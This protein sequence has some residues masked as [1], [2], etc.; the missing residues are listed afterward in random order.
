LRHMHNWRHVTGL[1]WGGDVN[2]HVAGQEE[3]TLNNLQGWVEKDVL[4]ND[5]WSDATEFLQQKGKNNNSFQGYWKS[6]N[7]SHETQFW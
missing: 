2:V 7:V 5:W 6:M 1:G 4:L 3:S